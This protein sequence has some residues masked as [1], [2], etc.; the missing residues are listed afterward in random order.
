MRNIQ[1]LKKQLIAKKASKLFSR[2]LI[3][4]EN[5]A[6]STSETDIHQLR[7]SV[8]KWR[9]LLNLAAF[10]KAGKKAKKF[11]SH[12]KKV[13]KAS[14]ELREIQLHTVLINNSPTNKN[15]L[16]LLSLLEK[17]KE[18]CK[19]QFSN[20]CQSTHFADKKG[21]VKNFTDLISSVNPK[22]IAKYRAA[23]FKRT[24]KLIKQ[25]ASDEQ[26]LHDLRKLL[27]QWLYNTQFLKECGYTFS[28][29]N[30]LI[31]LLSAFGELLGNWQD[32]DVA[33]QYLYILSTEK[34]PLDTSAFRSFNE[35][36]ILEKA[37][38]QRQINQRI[39]VLSEFLTK[40]CK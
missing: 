6:A 25:C 3:N 11:Y 16:P 14:G 30:E 17:Q 2:F 13:Y 36:L 22:S 8:K 38:L 1:K 39:L 23:C 21:A 33:I 26:K 20:I 24:E 4:I 18:S 40:I 5:A 12:Y 29:T 27:K 35:G 7:V 28:Y 10:S 15:M 31:T 19:L 32:K 37:D 9:A 34:S